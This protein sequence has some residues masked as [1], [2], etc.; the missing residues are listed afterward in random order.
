MGTAKGRGTPKRGEDGAAAA[1]A[2][3]G[4]DPRYLWP[5][6]ETREARLAA[7]TELVARARELPAGVELL[8]GTR[9][10]PA[11][12][13][14]L[15][16][17]RVLEH[18]TPKRLRLAAGIV[19]LCARLGSELREGSYLLESL[20]EELEK[21]EP[22]RAP[23]EAQVAALASL[24]S[25]G[26]R[27]GDLPAEAAKV[28]SHLV[29]LARE[30]GLGLEYLLGNLEKVLHLMK[31]FGVR[32][33]ARNLSSL[34][35]NYASGFFACDLSAV[36]PVSLAQAVERAAALERQ[37]S[38]L[39]VF[40]QGQFNRGLGACGV[41][42]LAELVAETE[43]SY[44]VAAGEV[45]RFF[46]ACLAEEEA[47]LA[48]A[49]A[50]EL[51]ALLR[52]FRFSEEERELVGQAA[53]GAGSEDP[54][55][56]MESELG[57]ALVT[58]RPRLNWL[59]YAAGVR[60]AGEPAAW[61]ADAGVVR[62]LEELS[63]LGRGL[64]V[65][66]TSGR[67]GTR[68]ERP[69]AELS[70]EA[71]LFELY[72]LAV[73]EKRRLDEVVQTAVR[74]LRLVVEL[75][76]RDPVARLDELVAARLGGES[77]ATLLGTQGIV[78]RNAPL[79]A[80][81]EALRSLAD[82]VEL[83][84][85]LDRGGAV[86]VA[87]VA[88]DDF[89]R[90]V[91]RLGR[92]L[93]TPHSPERVLAVIVDKIVPEVRR[94]PRQVIA[95][96]AHDLGRLVSLALSG[97]PARYALRR[98]WKTVNLDQLVTCGTGLEPGIRN[99]LGC[100]VNNL[101][102]TVLKTAQ[103]LGYDEIITYEA[104][105]C[106]EVY[107]GIWPYTGKVFPSLHGVFGGAASELLGGLAAK[108]ARAKFAAKHGA[109]PAASNGSLPRTLHL[110]WG[111]DGATFDIG[112]GN[113]SGL[114]SRLQRLGRDELAE[115]LHQRALYVCY[116]NEG[117]QN[118]GNQYSA[119]TAPGGNTTTNPR[120][121]A[122]TLGNDL[123]KKP[124]VEIIA[125]HG[126][127]LSA[128]LNIHRQQHISRVVARA[129]EDGD[130]GSFIHFLQPCTTGWK[131]TADSLTYDLSHLAEAGGLFSPVTIEHG[132]PYLELYPTPRDP[133]EVFMTLQARFKHLVDL[134]VTA[135]ADLERVMDYY[136]GEWQRNLELCGFEA[137]IPRAER[138]AY[139]DEDHRLPRVSQ[140]V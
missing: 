30:A 39:L 47:R 14:T 56:W 9:P 129:L 138:L 11:R 41:E 123:R 133:A 96:G 27:L 15:E 13:G 38:T 2:P 125:D 93:Q 86:P 68:E 26:L 139:L 102:G 132:V 81:L 113:L 78:L 24:A 49:P 126:V 73:L 29:A 22:A 8:L 115:S 5:A 60:Q 62:A 76:N 77:F 4:T 64:S 114:F 46:A 92:A 12:V 130:R 74:T 82:K 35:H 137:E 117:Y 131:F 33:R 45:R 94:L 36:A 135:K 51:A 106:F 31:A 111:G 136:R 55:H 28:P 57:R 79:L 67:R 50:L 85:P 108:R 112:F 128:R 3:G 32:S 53:G 71:L 140:G 48:A 37:G 34:Y 97:V 104:T 116:D 20:V 120:G 63:T 42:E 1:K 75:E 61:A 122:R 43:E 89:R 127:P 58:L 80:A 109:Q 95:P 65:T 7:A 25:R 124:I 121:K 72:C 83:A 66:L 59:A 17:E 98:P 103:S 84:V 54:R 110:G 16:P 52:C 69:L 99:C 107:S 19:E 100:P 40:A 101:Y 21:L 105:G 119:A 88:V 23:S 118:T 134:G 44:G 10:L 18:L 91:I 6:R 87:D 70:G 90:A